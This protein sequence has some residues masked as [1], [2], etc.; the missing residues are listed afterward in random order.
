MQLTVERGLA[1]ASV[2]AHPHMPRR[3]KSMRPLR[4]VGG[5][6]SPRAAIRST[7]YWAAMAGERIEHAGVVACSSGSFF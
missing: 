6:A 7:S 2:C 4:A 5:S 1:A 3:R